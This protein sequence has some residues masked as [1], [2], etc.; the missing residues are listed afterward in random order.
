MRARL[1]RLL[2]WLVGAAILLALVYRVPAAALRGGLAHGPWGLLAAYT[3]PFIL[4]TLAADAYATGVCLRIAG[5]PRPFGTL[6]LVR[7][8]TYLLGLL[9]Y[10]LGQGGIGLY[11]HRTGVRAVRGTGIV[12]FLLAVNF[13]ALAAAAASG[14]VLGGDELAGLRGTAIGILAAGAVYLGVIALRPAFLARREVLAPLFEAGP[15]GHL[16]ALAGR[17]PHLLLLILGHWGAM[18]IWGIRV[19]VGQALARMPAVILASVVPLSPSGLGTVQATQILLFAPYAPAAST[20]GREAAVLSYSLAF[21][22]LGLVSQALT[23]AV[24]LMSLRRRGL[25]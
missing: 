14:I 5:E 2:P 18:W 4:I 13:G 25:A 16:A 19:P 12:L 23:G 9:N 10:A 1:R 3:L 17:M 11:L 20:A 22:L 7:G 24:C 15:L 8:A 21:T 6:T